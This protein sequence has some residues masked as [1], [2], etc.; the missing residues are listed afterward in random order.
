MVVKRNAHKL[1]TLS[2]I[3]IY[4]QDS[5]NHTH[6]VFV[7]MPAMVSWR[8]VTIYQCLPFCW[9]T[10]LSHS[11]SD[12]QHSSHWL[13][14]WTDRHVSKQLTLLYIYRVIH[15]YQTG[16]LSKQLTLLY[17]YRVIHSYQTGLLSKKLTLLYIYRVIHSYQTG[18]LSQMYQICI[19]N[20]TFFFCS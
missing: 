20:I 13:K 8:L 1:Q 17:I 7:V 2:N 16:L 10:A 15:S 6:H 11:I 9:T 12:T 18:L 5:Q 19:Q 3:R 4:Q 14:K